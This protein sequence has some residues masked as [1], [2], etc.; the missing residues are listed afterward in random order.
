MKCMK[1]DET[2]K[3]IKRIKFENKLS[4]DGL[5]IQI[6]RVVQKLEQEMS[7]KNFNHT[8]QNPSPPLPRQVNSAKLLGNV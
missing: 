7:V 3:V 8:L 1:S 2:H 5:F 6:G 4:N